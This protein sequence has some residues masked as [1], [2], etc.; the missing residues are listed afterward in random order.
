MHAS[1]FRRLLL[2]TSL[3]MGVGVAAPV[4]AMADT[5]S[6]RSTAVEAK[7]KK[8]FTVK[9]AESE[10]GQILVDAKGFTL[11]A[12]DPDGTNIDESQC[13]GGCA[14]AWPPLEAKK[15]RAGKGLDAALLEV[16]AA[17]QVAYNG[18]LLYRYAGDTAPGDTT[19]HGVGGVWHAVGADGNPLA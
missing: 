7:K 14:S 18:H 1:T 16:G 5:A 15:A 8:K 17:G 4:A 19:G 9:I 10:L 6:T 12:F 3:V 11:Y 13:T 2:V